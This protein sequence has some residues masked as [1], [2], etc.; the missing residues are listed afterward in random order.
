MTYAF[1]P[2]L[3]ELQLEEE[4]R[5]LAVALP[6]H[7][8]SEGSYQ[9][10]HSDE[11]GFAEAMLQYLDELEACYGEMPVCEHEITL[12]SAVS[13]RLLLEGFDAWRE[14]LHTGDSAWA[15]HGSRLLVAVQCFS[16]RI[17]LEQ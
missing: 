7:L 3:R 9:R 2:D 16:N 5:A 8:W 12:E 17:N 13:H 15:E 14:A 11:D 6:D 4:L 1:K 10:F